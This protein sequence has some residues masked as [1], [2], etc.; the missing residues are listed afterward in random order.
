[1]GIQPRGAATPSCFTHRLKARG[2]DLLCS[3]KN[4]DTLT[5]ITDMLT[6]TVGSTRTVHTRWPALIID[7]CAS[8]ACSWV[9]DVWWREWQGKKK[10]KRLQNGDS[11]LREKP[12]RC[13]KRNVSAYRQ[14][15]VTSL[16]ALSEHL[17]W[18][19]RLVIFCHQLVF[20]WNRAYS[21]SIF[22]W[23]WWA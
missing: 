16:D 11:K 17:N 6:D 3:A 4:T 1:M 14:S 15:S 12:T 9:K 7:E 8:P 18:S 2:S 20:W 10:K 5:D 23:R 21:W 13:H 22:L 19:G